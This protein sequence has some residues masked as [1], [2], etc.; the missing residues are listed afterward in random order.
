MSQVSLLFFFAG[1]VTLLFVWL[2]RQ[3][4]KQH[5]A[6]SLIA[7]QIA[8]AWWCVT[9]GVEIMI[10]DPV[11]AGQWAILEYL[12]IITLPVFW[13]N[14]SLEYT[15]EDRHV[16]R[17][18]RYAVWV[19]PALVMIAVAT[20]PLHH[21]FWTRVAYQSDALIP[22]VVFS[23]GPLFWVHSAYSY[24]LMA[25]GA[26]VIMASGFRYPRYY[27]R[28]VSILILAALIP[29]ITNLFYLLKVMPLPGIDFTPLSFVLT[30]AVILY[31]ISQAGLLSLKPVAQDLLFDSILDGIVILDDQARL[32]NVNAAARTLLFIPDL[33]QFGTP[34]T[35]Y[36]KEWPAIAAT[37]KKKQ[38]FQ[39]VVFI[40][41]IRRHLD[42][43]VNAL[44][45]VGTDLLGW[46]LVLRDVSQQR[47]LEETFKNQAE[48]L[49][50]VIDHVPAALLYVTL[51]ERV[52]FF[53]HA[54]VRWIE[55]PAESLKGRLAQDILPEQAYLR[56]SHYFQLARAGE[57][58][59]F[60][61]ILENSDDSVGYV[62]IDMVPH[63]NENKRVIAVLILAQDF[64]DRHNMAQAERQQ[65]AW[66]EALR[67][68]VAALNSTLDYDEVLDIILDRIAVVLPHD[69]ANIV[70]VDPQ[71]GIQIWRERGYGR[72][73]RKETLS[74][75]LQAIAAFPNWQKMVAT[76]RP[77]A[78]PNTESD[79]DWQHI[80]ELKWVRSY[81]GA[82]IC[83]G[84]RVIG[85]LS[86]DSATPG[87]FTQTHAEH[88]MSFANEAAVAIEKA[89][90]Y[91]DVRQ[92]AEQMA[93]I[94]RIA[95][96]ITAG[97]DLDKVMGAI[98]EQ[99]QQV[100]PLDVFYIALYNQ[101]ANMIDLPLFF[102]LG[103]VR[104]MPARSL[105]EN[106][107]LTGY[108]IQNRETVYIPDVLDSKI[109]SPVPVIHLG[110]VSSR[111]YLGV[112]LILRDRVIGVISIQTYY[113]SAY[114]PDQIRLLEVIGTQAAIALENARLYAEAQYMA[115]TDSL[116]GLYNRRYLMEQA[117]VLVEEAN[118]TSSDL[119]LI[120]LDGDL[121]KR[122]NDTY[123]HL[124]GDQ[125]LK[126]IAQTCQQFLK[127]G[128]VV[129]RYGGEEFC[130]LLPGL[131]VQ[132][133]I[134]VAENICRALPE[135]EI[136][137]RGR[138][139][140]ISASFGIAQHLPGDTLEQTLSR[141]DEA[142]YRAKTGG[143]NQISV[144][145]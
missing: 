57:R 38:Q 18:L 41:D 64:T 52:I 60:D 90:L 89:R 78:I 85:F 4:W 68:T 51:D 24:I 17:V 106:P 23:H 74:I 58:I 70:L 47:E 50:H 10:S 59:S 140:S 112:P 129:G 115:I 11:V 56:I 69:A 86:L 139:F 103:E 131:D 6:R 110:G 62:H 132:A 125:A 113:P 16:N 19:I 83:V 48:Q 31:G 20:N 134:A 67:Q 77:M 66:A 28:Q 138:S 43:M 117:S 94:N 42:I 108:I 2:I 109:P 104:S 81:A 54:F 136:T 29:W 13:L 75:S 49:T 53:N 61:T 35:N 9:Y 116:T 130:I 37:L 135:T 145:L 12:A 30:G 33:P 95:N 96:A 98:L 97:L 76:A 55:Q 84:N 82:P 63:K 126:T 99:C 120:L 32:V 87:F 44:Y 101:E 122:V 1:G 7:M 144:S 72:Y 133:A 107:G 114:T 88:L 34:I 143:R 100:L 105:A 25:V 5:R 137:M 26:L 118:Q 121:F 80:P 142:L 119:S 73:S 39:R 65:R 127:L 3:H 46:V 21:L 79:P 45:D 111:C 36:I 8:I 27:R 40:P 14:F 128:Q 22:V 91:A 102:D 15:Q 92:R 141:A 71:E 124:A 93:S 123:G